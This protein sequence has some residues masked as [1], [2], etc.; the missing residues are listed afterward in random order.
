MVLEEDTDV[1]A[2]LANALAIVAVPGARFFDD[3]VQHREVENS[4]SREMPSP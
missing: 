2:A 4:P 3:V 1:F